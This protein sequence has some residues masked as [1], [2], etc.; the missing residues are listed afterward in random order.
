MM[1]SKMSWRL[2]ISFFCYL[3]GFL[4]LITLA[5]IYLFRSEFMPYHAVAVGQSWDDV[6]PAFQ[7]LIL[8]LMKVAGGG[9]FATAVATIILLFIPF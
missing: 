6:D 2:K 9:W 1:K 5:L 8:A 3:L 4:F 7:I